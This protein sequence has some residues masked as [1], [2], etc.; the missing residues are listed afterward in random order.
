MKHPYHIRLVG[1]HS[2]N[3]MV[4]EMESGYNE[5]G[6]QFKGGLRAKCFE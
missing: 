5:P 3:C 4:T 6:L 1:I 2:A